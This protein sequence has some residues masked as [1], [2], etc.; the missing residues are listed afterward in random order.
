MHLK[1]I[2]GEISQRG[3]VPDEFTYSALIHSAS[4]SGN[5]DEAFLLR[6]EMLRKGLS[7]NIV[8]YNSLLNGLCKLG[9]IDR[10]LRLF[11]KLYSKA[12]VPNLITYNTLIDGCFKND[13]TD[14]ANNLLK[15][16][17]EEGI[18]PSNTKYSMLNRNISNIGNM[19][20]I[21][22][23]LDQMDKMELKTSLQDMGH[24]V[25]LKQQV[26]EIHSNSTCSLMASCGFT[27]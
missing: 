7:P 27:K 16:M 20:E 24:H 4:I 14:D 11:H 9:K 3:F 17:T 19:E 5:V 2:I 6:D 18:S 26:H 21:V 8:T 13:R 25:K 10:A 12:L 15:R 22:A 1:K 23:L